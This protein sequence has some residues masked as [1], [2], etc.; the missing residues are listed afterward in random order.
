MASERPA[1]KPEKRKGLSGRALELAVLR[2]MLD[3]PGLVAVSYLQPDGSE[4]E[5]VTGHIPPEMVRPFLPPLPAKR[6][7]KRAIPEDQIPILYEQAKA[8][9]RRAGRAITDAQLAEEMADLIVKAGGPSDFSLS[10]ETIA[11]YR[12]SGLTEAA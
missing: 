4:S 9:L 2:L 10:P 3:D 5:P 12:K 6:G 7:R 11:N 8:N 1:T